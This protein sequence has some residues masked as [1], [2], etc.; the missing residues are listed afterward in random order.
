MFCS[1][2]IVYPVSFNLKQKFSV[3]ISYRILLLISFKLKMGGQ[4]SRIRSTKS[5]MGSCLV[6]VFLISA[7]HNFKSSTETTPVFLVKSYNSNI[8]LFFR[9]ENSHLI[10]FNSFIDSFFNGDIKYASPFVSLNP[11]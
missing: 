11:T 4:S 6:I 1:W 7:K 10:H 3:E 8:S 9:Y 5:S 2:D